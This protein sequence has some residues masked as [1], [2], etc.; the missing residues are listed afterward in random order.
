MR[1]GL[2]G[3]ETTHFEERAD[4]GEDDDCKYGDD[5]AID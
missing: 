5:A 2:K 1:A 3:S 4:D